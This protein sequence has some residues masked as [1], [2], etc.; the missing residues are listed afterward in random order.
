MSQDTAAGPAN[1]ESTQPVISETGA[2]VA[3]VSSA[4]DLVASDTNA[5]TDVFRRDI[6]AAVTARASVATLGIQANG[7]NSRPA[8]TN[9]GLTIA[10]DSTAT[11]LVSSRHERQARTCSCAASRAARLRVSLRRTRVSVATNGT[12]GNEEQ[13]HPVA[14]Q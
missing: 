1:G 2:Y 6:G 7:P 3:F 11:N 9:D 10:F 14:E 5:A 13:Q 4:S 12:E 8:M